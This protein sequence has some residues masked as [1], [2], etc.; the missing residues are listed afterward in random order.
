MIQIVGQGLAGTCVAWQ[1]WLKGTPFQLI[2]QEE[3]GSSRIA[4][5]LVTP[6]A[7]K[8]FNPSWE[9]ESYLPRALQFYEEVGAHLGRSYWQ[10]ADIYRLPMEEEER[11]RLREK[12]HECIWVREEVETV[13]GV[14]SPFGAFVI[15]G[16]GRLKIREWLDDSRQFF[17]NNGCYKVGKVMGLPEASTVVL[18]E[19]ALGLLTP[20]SEFSLQS[21]PAKGEILTVKIPGWNQ[22]R[23]LSA[24]GGWLI[25]LGEDL[26]RVGANY[27]W[28]QLDEIPTERGRTQVFEIL[29][30]FTDREAE[31]VAH[32]AAV[33][34][35]VR[36]SI[37]VIGPS[38]QNP[39][40]WGMNGL[41]SKG[42]IYAPDVAGILYRAIYEGGKIPPEFD[43]R[44]L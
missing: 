41:G 20:R 11:D 35:I 9:I 34:P 43:W 15:Q 39:Q 13:P 23:F 1:C 5:G 24:K 16:G 18:T 32:H 29:R 30:R 7:G 28:S 3:G 40:I 33:R 14:K 38:L 22:P 44:Q 21:R 27:E 12:S 31:V 42:V 19:G 17:K 36:R 37:P 4:A 26:Y 25:P 8:R 10:G 2:D 6:V